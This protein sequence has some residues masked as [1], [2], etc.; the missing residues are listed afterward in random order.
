[1]RHAIDKDKTKFASLK[2]GNGGTIFWCVLS[3]ACV[4]AALLVLL[5]VECTINAG[6]VVI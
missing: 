1:V 3:M 5:A 4:G 6:L 2:S